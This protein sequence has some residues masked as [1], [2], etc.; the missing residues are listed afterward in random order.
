MTRVQVKNIFASFIV[1]MLAVGFFAI[2]Q[3][4]KAGCC[5][6][7]G[8]MTTDFCDATNTCPAGTGGSSTAATC[9]TNATACTPGT[10]TTGGTTSGGG[11]TKGPSLT[12]PLEGTCKAGT[13]GQQCLQLI[14]G[15]VIKGA[16]GVTGSIAL[17]MI[18]WGGFLWLTSMGNSERV[19]KGKSTLIWATLGLVLIF[20]AYAI[21]SF[22][23]EK[24]VLGK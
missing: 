21:T 16:L 20:G 10:P 5:V 8:A 4:A 11:S 23:I 9:D 7:G 24:I 18:V 12:N 1:I 6:V 17:L 15:N 14:V 2:P 19:E 22:V 13:T 3:P